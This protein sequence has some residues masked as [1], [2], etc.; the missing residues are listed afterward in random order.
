MEETLATLDPLTVD[1]LDVEQLIRILSSNAFDGLQDMRLHKEQ[2]FLAILPVSETYGKRA[3]ALDAWKQDDGEKMLF[4]GAIDLLAEG[5]DGVR[6][7]DY[8]Y[9]NRSA[10][11]LREHYKPQLDLY[12]KAVASILKK[13]EK[14][15]S[16]TI[17]NIKQ[18]FEVNM[19]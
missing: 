14:M 1:L 6:I 10:E 15:V 2:E 4:Q 17:V 13:D 12:K 8:K 11:S 16:C 18:C 7:I 19:D 9:S 5:D 3:D